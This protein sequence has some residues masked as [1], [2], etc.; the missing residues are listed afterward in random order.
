MIQLFVTGKLIKLANP[1][2]SIDGSG[3]IIPKK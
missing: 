2:V 3:S 1:H